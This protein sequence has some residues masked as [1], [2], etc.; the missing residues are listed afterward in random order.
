MA[1]IIRSFG[2]A[3]TVT[4]A[5]AAITPA[6][7]QRSDDDLFTAVRDDNVAAAK[8][9]LA[10]HATPNAL[11]PDGS[12]VLAWAADRADPDMVGLLLKAGAK[13]NAG[14]GAVPLIMACE[15]GSD[16]IVSQLLDAHADVKPVRPDGVTALHLCAAHGTAK[17]V[18]RMIDAGASVEA[19]NSDGQTPLM[20]AASAGNADTIAVLLQHHA[21]INAAAKSGFTPLFFAAKGGNAKVVQTLL[22]AGADNSYVA[23]DGTT[24][25]HLALYDNDVAVA[26]VLVEHGAP[27]TTWDINGKQ[28]L[29]VAAANGDLDLAKLMVAKGADVNGLTRLPY[30]VDV[31]TDKRGPNSARVARA[32][33]P[34]A[35]AAAAAAPAPEVNAAV[36]A[37]VTDQR[38]GGG[39]GGPGFAAR[40]PLYYDTAALGYV[41]KIVLG[42]LDWA[43]SVADPAPPTTPLMAAAAAGQGD[44]IK[45][46]VQS[47]ANKDFTT[48]DGN[49]V[50]L[51]AVSSGSL[52]ATK[53]AL[54]VSPNIKVARKDGTTVMH[55]AVADSD[56]G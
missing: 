51:A 32:A 34:A 54:S 17:N 52:E 15:N 18:S 38:G 21:N 35:G 24:A 7:A 5:L 4:G 19:M 39:A 13:P 55:I 10:K 43:G 36:A 25:L 1:G 23:P 37:R 2:L 9:A 53:A 8:M 46:L 6:L 16:A 40:S 33:R 20:F 45:L 48:P 50:V 31:V 3:V 11:T 44:M 14:E 26:T 27:L 47:G 42:R 30:R 22:A 28:P 12:A 49:N 41:P 29:H 56:R